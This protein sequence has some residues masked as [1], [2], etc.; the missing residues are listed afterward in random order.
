MEPVLIFRTAPGIKPV[1]S[2]VLTENCYIYEMPPIDNDIKLKAW[3]GNQ[4]RSRR[5]IQ[6]RFALNIADLTNDQAYLLNK[7]IHNRV[8]IVFD[9]G[10]D[11]RT[12]L[13]Q[14]FRRG[15]PDTDE[16]GSIVGGRGT[17]TRTMATASTSATYTGPDGLIYPAGSGVPRYET[18]AGSILPGILIESQTGQY[19]GKSH[20]LSG[21]LFWTLNNISGLSAWG[22]DGTAES[23]YRGSDV[24]GV[25]KFTMVATGDYLYKSFTSMGSGPA[26]SAYVWVKGE[27][28]VTLHISGTV[29][30]SPIESAQLTLTNE[31]QMIKLED[32]VQSPTGAVEFRIYCRETGICEIGPGQV[33]GNPRC[34]S[35]IHNLS[36][37]ATTRPMDKLLYDVDL[38]GYQGM[39]HIGF[40]RPVFFDNVRSYLLDVDYDSSTQVGFSLHYDHGTSEYEFQ[41]KTNGYVAHAAPVV[42]AGND[43]EVAIH[44]SRNLLSLYEQGVLQDSLA[45]PSPPVHS[46]TSGLYIGGNDNDNDALNG[47]VH[48]VRAS[49]DVDLLNMP[50]IYDRWH[51]T[52][53]LFWSKLFEGRQFNIASPEH[54]VIAAVH[55]NKLQLSEVDSEVT[56]T[57][58]DK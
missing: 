57:T 52:D 2:I 27:G 24:D 39:L 4:Q 22:W 35:Y 8:P 5:S 29:V 51:D 31:W 44:F 30:G 56:A 38:E 55:H 49:R 47:V 9:T 43:T 21:D 18:P 11:D 1:E 37:S 40:N 28:K 12:F 33:E 10:Q 6:K 17:F 46:V 42:A 23:L 7:W 20:P 32:W 48:Y 36:G 26:W 19:F 58:E 16:V 45:M 54:K 41:K 13:H 50:A 3:Y 25:G 53:Q 14:S 15:D 34:T